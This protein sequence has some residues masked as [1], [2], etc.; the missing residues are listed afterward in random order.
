MVTTARN[1]AIL[2]CFCSMLQHKA[3]SSNTLV[4]AGS[5][6]H[7]LASLL[8]KNKSSDS[9]KP[10]FFSLQH[11]SNAQTTV[12]LQLQPFC[13]NSCFVISNRQLVFRDFVSSSKISDTASV[14]KTPPAKKTEKK[15]FFVF[16]TRVLTNQ[17]ISRFFKSNV[18]SVLKFVS[19]LT[20][21]HG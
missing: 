10:L 4:Q 11:Y 15:T 7:A 3:L 2:C 8:T 1:R 14:S 12:F 21:K 5:L 9:M 6:K 20:S 18:S 13:S 19:V 17:Y 16:L